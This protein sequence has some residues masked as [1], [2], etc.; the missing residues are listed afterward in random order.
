MIRQIVTDTA[1]LSQRS[2]P[3]APFDRTVGQ[4]LLDT[5]RA[6]QDR[7]VGLAA[8][9]IGANKRVIAVSDEGRLQVFYNPEITRSSRPYET[10]E[11]CLS[12]RAGD[13]A[14][15]G[16]PGPD[17]ADHTARVRPLRGDTGLIAQENDGEASFRGGLPLLCL[18]DIRQARFQAMAESA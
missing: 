8:N 9:M 3:A 18:R 13:A 15:T 2:E 7:C 11:G 16:L 14:R 6:N 12:G 4:D 10:E 1:F 5:L 17:R